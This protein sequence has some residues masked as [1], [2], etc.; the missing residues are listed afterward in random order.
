MKALWNKFVNVVVYTCHFVAM[1]VLYMHKMLLGE[2]I[3]LIRIYEK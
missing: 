1:H 2:N 3:M